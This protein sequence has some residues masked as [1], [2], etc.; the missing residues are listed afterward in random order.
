MRFLACIWSRNHSN[1]VIWR[2]GVK[3][4]GR[5]PNKVD[6]LKKFSSTIHGLSCGLQDRMILLLICVVLLQLCPH[7][8]RF[9]IAP[10]AGCLCETQLNWYGYVLLVTK[11]PSA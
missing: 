11:A 7:M 5:P 9:G 1:R 10:I 2:E 6:D 4:I 8:G 3:E